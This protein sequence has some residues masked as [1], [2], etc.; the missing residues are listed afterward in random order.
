MFKEYNNSF[1]LFLLLFCMENRDF[2]GNR[3][4]QIIRHTILGIVYLF[5]SIGIATDVV[6]KNLPKK[7]I[8]SFVEGLD[9][10]EFDMKCLEKKLD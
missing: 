2:L 9:S 6:E 8:S 3:Y 4:V 7:V 5:G 10:L 1:K